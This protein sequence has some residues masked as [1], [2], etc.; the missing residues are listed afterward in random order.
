MRLLLR[1]CSLIFKRD[2]KVCEKQPF[3][4][5]YEEAV[6]VFEDKFSIEAIDEMNTNLEEIRYKIIGRIRRQVVLL[7][8]YAS[9]L[10][11]LIVDHFK[12]MDKGRQT[13]L[14]DFLTDANRIKAKIQNREKF[15]AETEDK[16]GLDS[17]RK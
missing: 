10:S 8:V 15:Y 11:K 5:L 6:E 2:L 14:N 17:C 12:A 1:E 4:L 3:I 9:R 7:V 16:S 13:K